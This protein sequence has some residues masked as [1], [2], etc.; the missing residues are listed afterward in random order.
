M[1][2]T[3]LR[4]NVA[5]DVVV[6]KKKS[7]LKDI[8]DD[9]NWCL[10]NFECEEYGDVVKAKIILDYDDQ[11]F[12]VLI[13]TKKGRVNDVNCNVLP[14]LAEARGLKR[15]LERHKFENSSYTIAKVIPVE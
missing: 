4:I 14:T 7:N 3:T 10:K 15:R 2:P 5:M 13:G 1:K 6:R 9:V 12:V 8:I 11:K